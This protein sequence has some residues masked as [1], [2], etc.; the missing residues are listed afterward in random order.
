[1][2]I[3]PS[4]QGYRD[5]RRVLYAKE[6]RDPL[7]GERVWPLDFTETRRPQPEQEN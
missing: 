4:A 5:Y 3:N 7:T 6:R 1:M 2:T